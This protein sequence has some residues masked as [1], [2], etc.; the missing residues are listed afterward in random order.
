MIVVVPQSGFLE[1]HAELLFT[2]SNHHP[3]QELGVK[4]KP[5]TDGKSRLKKLKL[6]FIYLN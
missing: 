4:P 1:E 3:K 6:Y 2:Q 5:F